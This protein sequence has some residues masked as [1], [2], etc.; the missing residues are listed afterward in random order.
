MPFYRDRTIWSDDEMA[1]KRAVYKLFKSNY[2]RDEIKHLLEKSLFTLCLCDWNLSDAEAYV[3]LEISRPAFIKLRD[4]F[5]FTRELLGSID[6]RGEIREDKISAYVKTK[7][8]PQR[9]MLRRQLEL[10]RLREAMAEEQK[11]IEA[12]TPFDDSLCAKQRFK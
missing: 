12:N 9:E 11:E 3:L 4:S 8:L 6:D 1:L 2:S 5:C 7:I 10:N